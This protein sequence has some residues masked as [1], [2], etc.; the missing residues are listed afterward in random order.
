MN[1]ENEI[2]IGV[3]GENGCHFSPHACPDWQ[4]H[5]PRELNGV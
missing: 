4:G 1:E 5:T 3:F 2:T